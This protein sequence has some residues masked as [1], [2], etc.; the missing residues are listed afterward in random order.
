MS[1]QP[2]HLHKQTQLLCS[3]LGAGSPYSI[4]SR[5]NLPATTPNPGFTAYCP[6]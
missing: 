6:G 2:T 1:I 3:F 4:G 5:S